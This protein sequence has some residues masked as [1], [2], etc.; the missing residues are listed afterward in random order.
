MY[1]W[2]QALGFLGVLCMQPCNVD[3]NPLT[4]CSS[5]NFGFC[6][7]AAKKERQQQRKKKGK[8]R[9][10]FPFSGWFLDLELS[11]T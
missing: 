3:P 5:T 9:S 8:K 11:Y 2:L 1:H 4:L 7:L 10:I 6:F